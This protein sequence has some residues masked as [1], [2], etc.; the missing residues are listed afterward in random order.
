MSEMNMK[1]FDTPT[2]E[3]LLEIRYRNFELEVIDKAIEHAKELIASKF[4]EENE[5]KIMEKM[6]LTGLSNLI[7]IKASEALKK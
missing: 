1:M 7:A 4:W 6:D 2:G 3:K 5:T